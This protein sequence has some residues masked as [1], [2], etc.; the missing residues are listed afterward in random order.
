MS[1][2]DSDSDTREILIIYATETGNARDVGVWRQISSSIR[3]ARTYANWITNVQNLV[4]DAFFAPR[5]LNVQL[6]FDQN[7]SKF[8]NIGL[9][10]KPR[11]SAT[12]ITYRRM[13]TRRFYYIPSK[14]GT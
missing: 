14:F 4:I 9:I 11:D 2:S 12:K 3:T 10:G 5:F 6:G 1:S 13:C 7:L 8:G